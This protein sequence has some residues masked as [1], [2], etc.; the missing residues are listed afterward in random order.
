MAKPR[1]HSEQ[2]RSAR[3]LII[4]DE[5]QN[6][7]ILVKLLRENGYDV[8]AAR[9]AVHA[10]QTLEIETVDLILL[11]IRMPKMTGFEFCETL[12]QEQRTASIP[13]I[14]LTA[15]NE[16]EDKVRGL[17][18]GA[19]DYITKPFNLDEVLARV[20]RQLKLR[21]EHMAEL[22]SLAAK[23]QPMPERLPKPK[24]QGEYRKSGLD[25]EKRQEIC[26]RFKA[27]FEEE[28]PY[29]DEELNVE[30]IAGQ[31]NVT[32]HNLSEAVNVEMKR[33]IAYLIN[34]YRIDHFCELLKQQPDATI[35][36]LA[37]QSGYNSK[38]VFNRWFKTI[39]KTTPKKFRKA[40][41]PGAVR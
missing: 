9:D 19:V 35:L 23:M 5:P 29:L 36:D 37:F 7:A 8:R 31:L 11:D 27:C 26:R 13:V 15:L 28:S 17:E 1:Q 41:S 21:S 30:T 24:G 6:I 25:P 39:K 33:S 16:V 32:R 34:R 20:A 38:S 12:K 40:L 4:D 10:L 3:I 22:G 14:F 2:V 18:L